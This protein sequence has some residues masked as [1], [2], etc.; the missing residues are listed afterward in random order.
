V[1]WVDN[2]DEFRGYVYWDDSAVGFRIK[3]P[4]GYM[5]SYKLLAKHLKIIGN[6]YEHPELLL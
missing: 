3:M 5:P 4:K 1:E 2:Y 6:I